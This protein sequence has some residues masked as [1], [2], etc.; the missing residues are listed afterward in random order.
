MIAATAAMFSPQLPARD[1]PNSFLDI[2][3]P[4]QS[5][6]MH[7]L[8]DRNIQFSLV[9]WDEPELEA[10]HTHTSVQLQ[11]AGLEGGRT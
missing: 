4:S 3:I 11:E 9:S 6:L 8:R 7:V 2:I 1:R 5:H 10:T